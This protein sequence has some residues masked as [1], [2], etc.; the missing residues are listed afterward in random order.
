MAASAGILVALLNNLVEPTMGSVPSYKTLAIIVLGGL[1]K[2]EYTDDQSQVPL[3]IRERRPDL[4][5]PSALD[6]AIMR[7]L[8]KHVDERPHDALELEGGAK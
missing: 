4:P 5:I 1:L 8:R 6:E 7:T 3:R 2:D